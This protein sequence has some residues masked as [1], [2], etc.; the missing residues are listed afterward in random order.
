MRILIRTTFLLILFCNKAMSQDNIA[1]Q[2]N[3]TTVYVVDLQKSTEFY[4]KVMLLKKMEEPFHDGRHTWFAVGPHTQLHVVQGAKAIT[5]HGVNIHNAFTV[6]SLPDFM[7]HLDDM[8][9]NYGNMAGEKQV[10]RRTDG[11]EQVYF[12][13]PD[14]YW[15]EVNNDKF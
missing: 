3:H 7:R 11:I 8:H 2:F 15:I 4:E 1:P 13:D 5:E 9:I 6:K 10:Q 14:G 12:Q